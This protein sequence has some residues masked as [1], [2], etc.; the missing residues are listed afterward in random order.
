MENIQ[1]GK[2]VIYK[3]KQLLST[4]KTAH[5]EWTSIYTLNKINETRE[6]LFI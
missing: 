1:Q 5:K 2:V 6:I 3:G 4:S